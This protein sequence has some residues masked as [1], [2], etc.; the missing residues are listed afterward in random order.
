[1]SRNRTAR[2]WVR[3]SIGPAL[4]VIAAIV[5]LYAPVRAAGPC[6]APP[7]AGTVVDPFRAPACTWCPGNRGIEYVVGTGSAVRAVAGG[8]VTFSGEIAGERYVVVE[9]ASGWKITYGRIGSTALM[10]GDVVVAGSIVARTSDR[11]FLGLRIDDEYAD[12]APHLGIEVG[13]RR[14]IPLDGR[15]PRPAPPLRLRCGS[16]AMEV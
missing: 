3:S 14:L 2:S 12:P 9:L 4:L 15:P 7:V 5:G 1:M 8:I 10:A 13:R 11:F 16:A 6:W